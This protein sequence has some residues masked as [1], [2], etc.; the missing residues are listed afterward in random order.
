MIQWSNKKN[1]L[2]SWKCQ[3]Q[4]RRMSR[5]SANI[6]FHSV[7]HTKLSYGFRRLQFIQILYTEERKSYWGCWNGKMGILVSGQIVPFLKWFLTKTT[8]PTFYFLDLLYYSV[9]DASF[10]ISHSVRSVSRR[11]WSPPQRPFRV[12]SWNREVKKGITA[13]TLEELKEKVWKGK[14]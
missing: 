4:L 1:N 2:A 10:P 7:P 3:E 6:K 5:F 8:L 11:V 14:P 9:F 13:G 12:C